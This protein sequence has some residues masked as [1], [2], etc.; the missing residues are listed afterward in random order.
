[1][2]ILCNINTQFYRTNAAS[3]SATRTAPWEGWERCARVL[4][5]ANSEKLDGKVDR[6]I[7]RKTE[8][9]AYAFSVFDM[10]C[11]NLRFE[12]FLAQRFPCTAFAF[13][14]MD[15]CPGL[16][17]NEYIVSAYM[18]DESTPN[19]HAPNRQMPNA[20]IAPLNC[21]EF[22]DCDIVEGFLQE[23]NFED[24]QKTGDLV[25]APHHMTAENLAA[26]AQES[27]CKK[28]AFLKDV[29]LCNLSVSFGFMHH[30]P[31]QALRQAVLQALVN[32]TAPGGFIMCSFWQFLRNETLAHKAQHT[33]EEA[34]VQISQRVPSFR[35]TEL[36]ENDYFLG[37]K[38]MPGQYRYCHNFTEREI[39]ELV[40]GLGTAVALV[41]KF[42]ADGRSH[43]LNSY[44][45]LQKR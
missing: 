24:S 20:P 15:N 1:M 45:I 43:N 28:P 39:D 9:A 40:F 12:Q 30:V 31:A 4:G 10:A 3:F 36:E 21:L 16:L 29:P 38:N 18:T 44:I 23:I 27:G 11:G 6:K 2:R 42:S 19:S 35:A 34:L 37:W 7:S 5:E 32:K 41:A 33:H 8:R 13:Y 17:P 14:A 25:H 22:F 26:P